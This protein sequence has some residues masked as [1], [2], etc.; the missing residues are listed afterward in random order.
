MITVLTRI[1]QM[2]TEFDLQRTTVSLVTGLDTPG[3]HD[4]ASALA[5]RDGGVH[6]LHRSHDDS[7][8][9]AAV[10]G[11][12][13]WVLGLERT[14]RAIVE[15][16]QDVDVVETAFLLEQEL[17]YNRL[18]GFRVELHDVIAVASAHQ[19]WRWLLSD[20]AAPATD[21]VTAETLASSLEFATT[22]ILTDADDVPAEQLASTLG[23][24]RTLNPDAVVMTFDDDTFQTG[25]GSGGR[26]CAARLGQGMGWSRALAT[27]ERS[28]ATGNAGSVVFRDPRPFHPQRLFDVLTTRLT[29]HRVGR[30]AR[31]R[32]LIYLA[33]RV[34]YYGSWRSAGDTVSLDP[35]GIA[36]WDINAPTGQELVFFG[37]ELDHDLLH[38]VLREALLTDTELLAGTEAWSSF[39]DPFPAWPATHQH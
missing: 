26:L 35:A 24:L 18:D 30:I 23:F 2:T 5:I 10:H 19:I 11:L 22:I 29:P 6:T 12:V 27:P 7:D 8:S 37:E 38:Q 13:E 25:Q 34:G 17:E 14:R 4:R 16:A 20:E 33:T 31:S 36:S 1:G 9:R 15:L 21:Y 3:R 39:R 32:G 28:G